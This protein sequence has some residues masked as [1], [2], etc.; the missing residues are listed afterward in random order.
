MQKQKGRVEKSEE[1]GDE[2]EGEKGLTRNWQDHDSTEKKE[3]NDNCAISRPEGGEKDAWMFRFALRKL[4]EEE[5]EGN[6]AWKESKTREGWSKSIRIRKK[7]ETKENS[8]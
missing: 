5:K 4:I 7:T 1:E 3:E 8:G 6:K 2:A